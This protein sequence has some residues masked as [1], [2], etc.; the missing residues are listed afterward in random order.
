M[1]Q[2]N[3]IVHTH[4]RYATAF[5]ILGREIP[6]V[7]TAM[8]DEFGGPIPVD[9]PVRLIHGDADLEVPVEVAVRTLRQLRSAD[10][11]LIALK[12][13][14]HRLSEPHEIDQIVRTVATLLEPAP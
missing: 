6:C 10:V 2:V 13:G 9:C 8:A 7:T 14:G 5:A 3:G 11:Q 12:G 1:P 4:S